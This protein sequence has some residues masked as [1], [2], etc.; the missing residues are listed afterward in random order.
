MTIPRSLDGG[1]L[2]V[3]IYIPENK[4][5]IG[6]STIFNRTYI[7]IGHTSQWWIFQCHVSFQGCIYVLFYLYILQLDI[8]W[9]NQKR[10]WW[11]FVAKIV[12]Q[13]PPHWGHIEERFKVQLNVAM[14]PMGSFWDGQNPNGWNGCHCD[15]IDSIDF[16]HQRHEENSACCREF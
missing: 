1:C 14:G 10:F 9:Q 4:H 15:R 13:K 11:F 8:W 2:C 7:S 12:Q 16:L 5:D 6:K 3:N